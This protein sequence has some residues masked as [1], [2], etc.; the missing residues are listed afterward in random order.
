ML[1]PIDVS[2]REFNELMINIM[3]EDSQW[4]DAFQSRLLSSCNHSLCSVDSPGRC[5]S[6]DI[7]NFAP[8]LPLTSSDAHKRSCSELESDN[9]QDG[10]NCSDLDEAPISGAEFKRARSDG[11][12]KL[13]APESQTSAP[14]QC[15]FLTESQAEEL[16]APEFVK[17]NRSNATSETLRL[18]RSALATK[19]SPSLSQIRLLPT[20]KPKGL[21]VEEI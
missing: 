5:K 7:F 19:V 14:T 18:V 6:G 11:H 4:L 2:S 15:T 3:V 21:F 9:Y 13:G 16:P 17:C 8:I 1:T 12:Y 10:T 20:F